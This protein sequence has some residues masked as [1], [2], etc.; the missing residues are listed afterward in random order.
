MSFS[1]KNMWSPYSPDTNPLA[2]T[3]WVHVESK[4]CTVRH[5]NINALKDTVNQHWGAMSEN[6]ICNGCKAFCGRLE[7]IIAAK[8]AT[9]IIVVAKTLIWLFQKFL[10][11]QHYWF[12]K[13]ILMKF[14]IESVRIFS[15]HL[16]IGMVWVSANM[17]RV[18]P[19]SNLCLYSLG[20]KRNNFGKI[21]FF[22]YV[23]FLCQ[24]HL[25]LFFQDSRA[26]SMEGLSSNLDAKKILLLTGSYLEE[27]CSHKSLNGQMDQG[28]LLFW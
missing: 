6:Y 19:S 26:A 24:Q 10:L 3:F 4:L 18:A 11:T 2:F 25:A 9:S 15:P 17:Q 14:Y 22:E 8:G 21:A 28:S 20:I 5:P 1:P 12:P 7:A 23:N 13:Y 27:I 16:V